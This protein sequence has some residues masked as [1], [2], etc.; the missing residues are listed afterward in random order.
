[1]E[2]ES[3]H[4]LEPPL[5]QDLEEL[6]VMISKELKLVLVDKLDHV[7]VH[8]EPGLLGD[9]APRLVERV[10]EPVLGKNPFR[11][12]S[13]SCCPLAQNTPLGLAFP[14]PLGR[15]SSSLPPF[16]FLGFRL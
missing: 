9:L 16:P 13:S 7:I 6:H 4:V 1:M 14:P 15:A 12:S 3:N 10:K 8:L 2:L 5:L 11:P